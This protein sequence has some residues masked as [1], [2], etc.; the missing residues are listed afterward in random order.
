M[1]GATTGKMG[2][3]H[4]ENRAVLNQ[5]V[6]NIKIKDHT[7]LYAG[8][9]NLLMESLKP[10]IEEIAY[11]GAQPNIS[12]KMICALPIPLPPLAEQKRIVTK[13]EELFA[14]L[15]IIANALK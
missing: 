4:G 13:V 8:F 10:I 7:I 12:S 6:G 11:G 14:Q 15:D 9:R 3:Y 2:I 1:S 5:R